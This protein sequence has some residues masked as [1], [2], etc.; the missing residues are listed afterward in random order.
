[1]ELHANRAA[2]SLI[3]LLSLL[4]CASA[5]LAAQRGIDLLN[6]DE[7]LRPSSPDPEPVE[8]TTATTTTTT[9]RLVD[10][11]DPERVTGATHDTTRYQY[12]NGDFDNY[13]VAPDP[14]RPFETEV[15][16]RFELSRAGSLV[17]IEV[18]FERPRSDRTRDVVFDLT[19]YRDNNGE[20]GTVSGFRYEVTSR[21]QP[22]GVSRCLSF[23]DSPLGGRGLARGAHWVGIAWQGNTNKLLGEDHYTSLDPAPT[24][25]QR[26][27]TSV[28]RRSRDDG[29]PWLL[30]SNPQELAS[31]RVKAYGIRLVVD[32]SV[33]APEPPPDPDPDPDPEPTPESACSNGLCLL[34]DG[35]FR[36]R[37]RYA[38]RGMP[39]QSAG[40]IAAG[41]AGT[42][43]LF[44][45]GG[46]APELLVRMVND[47]SGSGYW[48]LY[49][50]AATDADY[51]IAVRDTT[52]DE[53]KWFR[54][55]GGAATRDAMAFACGSN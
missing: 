31:P 17:S 6:A 23:S 15:A 34:E 14:F 16:Q 25:N 13:G 50:G 36:V 30:W 10:G 9:V 18:C 47:C 12:D 24:V 11:T 52:T 54:G 2:R 40:T 33:H 1:M 43:G 42:A 20:P 49:A 55:R 26:H 51:S 22:A 7:V 53:L 29:G 28:R 38:M 3:C 27:A 4:V 19:F 32:H 39:G 46:D 8:L 37:A 35:Q 21:I 45:F 44:T 5:P 41:L 48:M